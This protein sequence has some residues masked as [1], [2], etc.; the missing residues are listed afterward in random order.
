MIAFTIQLP[1][2]SETQRFQLEE[3]LLKVPRVD[4]FSM[5]QDTGFF[6]VTTAEDTLRDMVATLYSWASNYAGMLLQTAVAC[7][8]RDAMVLGKHS[9]N[10][11][12]HYLAACR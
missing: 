7:N 3:A 5:D 1:N 6:S 2:L 11:I 12:I 10:D 9:P 8:D 4:A